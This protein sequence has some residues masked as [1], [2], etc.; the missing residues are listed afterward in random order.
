MKKVIFTIFSMMSFTFMAQAQFPWQAA[1]IEDT[2]SMG[3]GLTSDVFYSFNTGDAGVAFNRSY[4]L[5]FSMSPVIDS[6]AIWAN[7]Q[8]GN[9][10]TK[11]FN[12]HKPVSQFATV[13]L[14]DTGTTSTLMYNNDKGW[15]NG[16]FNNITSGNVFNFGWGTYDPSVHNVYGDSVFIVRAS[17]NYYKIKIDSLDGI[18][19]K[20]YFTVENLTTPGAATSHTLSKT[21]N[22][23][24]RNFA[25]FN[26]ATL[27]DTNREPVNT[28]WDILFC[29]YTT[30]VVGSGQGTNNNVIGLLNNKGIKV[31]KAAMVYADSAYDKYT[32]YTIDTGIAAIG[33]NWKVFD[34]ANNV[35]IITDSLSYFVT[36]K[37]G[38]WWQLQFLDFTGTQS[39]NFIFRKRPV[40]PTSVQHI[41]SPINQWAIV[42]NPA[43]SNIQLLMDSKKSEAVTIRIQN[44]VGQVVASFSSPMQA[45]FNTLPLQL[46]SSLASGQYFITLSG[47]QWKTTSTLAI[48]H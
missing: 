2:V 21:P 42:P 11:V 19:T 3:P 14:A 35:Y 48:Q 43:Q 46:P 30:D 37:S 40:Y 22:Y 1:W 31:A 23:T 12:V 5:A 26:L 4:H 18:A 33:Y 38:A 17:G 8:A 36:D 7:H 16:A 34:L 9:A 15:Y 28:A 25:Y 45:G 27:A 20:Y 29:R 24:G 13:G 39:G 47:S 10:F 44:S 41:N 6:A 32:T